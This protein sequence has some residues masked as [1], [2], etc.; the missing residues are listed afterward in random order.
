[1]YVGGDGFECDE[2]VVGV[3]AEIMTSNEYHI[4]FK[5]SF[6]AYGLVG[7]IELPPNSSESEQL[8]VIYMVRHTFLAA[9]ETSMDPDLYNVELTD[10]FDD[11][12]K[13]VLR[14]TKHIVGGIHTKL[15]LRAHDRV[16]KP[17]CDG[18]MMD[19][20]TSAFTAAHAIMDVYQTECEEQ[21][22]EEEQGEREG[23]EEGEEQGERE[24]EGE[25]EGEGVEE[26]EGEG[27]EEEEGEGE[28]EEQG[29]I[30]ED[31][32]EDEWK[33]L[34]DNANACGPECSCTVSHTPSMKRT[35]LVLCPPC[36]FRDYKKHKINFVHEK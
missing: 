5:D 7:V 13:P 19:P 27:E 25:E 29:D 4:R 26:G 2:I 22:E 24:R 32:T 23:E 21:G 33:L 20:I 11:G 36:R 10:Y 34:E 6:R 9:L 31:E 1:M 30:T 8:Y 17:L 28:G 35:F 18:L 3:D 15:V 14:A 12:C 16:Q